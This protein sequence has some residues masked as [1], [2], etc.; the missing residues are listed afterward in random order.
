MLRFLFYLLFLSMIN[1][2]AHANYR[3][4]VRKIGDYTQIINPIIAASMAPHNKGLGHFALIFIE[5]TVITHAIKL[6]GVGTKIPISKRPYAAN[7]NGRYDGMPSG[8]TA[9]AWTAAAY[10][11]HFE[12]NKLISIPFYIAAGFTGY[13]R[14]KAQKHTTAQVIGAAAL[15]ELIV[16]LN[17]QS[18][19]SQEYQSYDVHLEGNTISSKIVL[20]F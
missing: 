11:R 5:D 18:Q 6:I 4:Q 17:K 2:T 15:A 12:E 13:S 14:I 7:R 10:I 3:S 9:S 8:H 19:W 1:L 20:K 16:Y